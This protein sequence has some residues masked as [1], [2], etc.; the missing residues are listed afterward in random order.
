MT[1]WKSVGANIVASLIVGGVV[2]LFT[3]KRF[4]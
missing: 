3:T 2:F 4:D 1:F